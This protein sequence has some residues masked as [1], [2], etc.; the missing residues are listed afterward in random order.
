MCTP[1][2]VVVGCN[3][4]KRKTEPSRSLMKILSPRALLMAERIPKR[5]V[6]LRFESPVDR[7][8]VA[9]VANGTA[10]CAQRVA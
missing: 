1:K 3:E 8:G 4:K 7:G 6:K 2:V 5:L 9:P 10:L